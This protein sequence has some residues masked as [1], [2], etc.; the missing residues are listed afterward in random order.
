MNQK[1]VQY[2]KAAFILMFATLFAVSALGQNINVT[3]RLNTATNRDTLMDHHVVQI[4]GEADGEIVPAVTWGDDTGISMV[5]VGGDYWETTFQIAPGTQLKYKFWTGF[6][7]ATST[8]FWGGWE[9]PIIPG[10]P[11]DSGDNRYFVAGSN[12]TTLALQFYH[13]TESPTN[14]YWR[15][16]EEKPD[17]FAVYFKVSMAALMETHD[18][19]PATDNVVVRG[20]TPLDPTDSWNTE[21]QLAQVAG[22]VDNGAFF[23]GAGYIAESDV[24]GGEWQNF[25]FV[26][27]KGGSAVWESTPNRFFQ[28]S[29]PV[30]TTILW[31]YFNNQ[32]PTGG[33][34]VEATLTWQVKT[35]GLEKLGLFDRSLGEHIIIDGAKAWDTE[36]A[37][38]MNY[39]P[40]LQLWMG[41]EPF[42]KAPGATL[43]YKTVIIWDDSR[44]DP[45]SPNYLPGLD[46]EV[47][48]QYWEEPC[49][50]GS[51]NRNYVYTDQTDQ[52]VPGDF[53]L[54][55]Q[56]F[57]GLPAEGVIETP[58]TVTFSIDMTPAMDIA[59]N[60]SNPLFRPGIDTVWV[61]FY[62]CLLPLT[63]GD[64]IY[65]N[66]PFQLDDTDGDL[67]YSGSL[68]LIPPVPFDVGF[69]VN[70]SSETGA[71]IQNGGGFQRGRSYYQFVHPTAVNADGTIEWP[72][73][74]DFPVLEWMDSDL[75]VEDPP[76]LWTAATDV[77]TAY[78]S[79]PTF[80]LA[81]N[82]PNPFNP[83]TTVP[84][85]VARKS[86]VCICVHNLNGQVV[87]T[88]V[89][90]DQQAGDYSVTWNGTDAAGRAVSTGIYFIRMTAE[91]YERVQKITLLR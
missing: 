50:N 2:W 24:L 1:A 57:N 65:T 88:L 53:G 45:A 42:I 74:F 51:G 26:Y 34:I 84:Y 21:V 30:D 64:G 10:N 11:V 58:I 16:Y 25:K 76:D 9:G 55:W 41:Q 83:E 18:F 73:Q 77:E 44:V 72:A 87:K 37:I 59:T 19:D 46:L 69:R 90:T 67:I 60:P 48:L 70:Y 29:A 75:T 47:P 91:S 8:F 39:V 35:D 61:Q 49:V 33:N 71:V 14:Q 68:P 80:R 81:Q 4:R 20:S 89:N 12:D 22:S 79:G 17:T 13:G 15:P 32:K 6:D 36:N 54:D 43:E 7:N 62:G 56:Y 31:S 23:A 85:E 82:F 66:T 3:I 27:N 52:A 40:L 78:E 38:E 28:Y 86:H 63:Q 5:N